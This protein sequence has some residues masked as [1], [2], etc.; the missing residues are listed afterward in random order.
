[1][2]LHDFSPPQVK[3]DKASTM[4][5]VD[6]AQLCCS[7]IFHIYFIYILY[8]FH[9]DSLSCHLCFLLFIIFSLFNAP[10]KLKNAKTT[11]KKNQT[12]QTEIARIFL[13]KN[14]KIKQMSNHN[15]FFFQ[16]KI[17]N[18]EINLSKSN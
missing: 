16:L 15:L 5:A 13:K 14:A 8:I 6:W 12:A 7:G 9:I 2:L 3:V 17:I 11:C 4:I 18:L 10:K 1:M